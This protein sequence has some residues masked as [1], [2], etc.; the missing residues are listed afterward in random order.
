MKK[1]FVRIGTL[2]LLGA[3]AGWLYSFLSRCAGST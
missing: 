3:G 2:G 1:T